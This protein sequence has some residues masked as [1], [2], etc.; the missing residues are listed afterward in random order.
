M[1]NVNRPARGGRGHSRQVGP[2]G[3]AGAG[4]VRGGRGRDPKNRRRLPSPRRGIMR[5]PVVPAVILTSIAVFGGVEF[6]YASRDASV[7]H[8]V[9]AVIGMFG[10]VLAFGWFR[11]V[12]NS[13]SS[14]GS[15]SDWGFVSSSTMIRILLAMAWVLGAMNLF[16]VVYEFAR[17]LTESA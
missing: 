1:P 4:Q 11:L 15:F 9:A 2:R 8:L 17:T 3:G 5:P 14:S 6:V 12:V 16:L 13:R 10:S 7:L